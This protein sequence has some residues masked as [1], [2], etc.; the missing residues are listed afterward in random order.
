VNRPTFDD[1]AGA[2]PGGCELAELLSAYLDD[3]LRAPERE[4]VARHLLEHDACRRELDEIAQVRAAVRALPWIDGPAEF[5]SELAVE[6]VLASNSATGPVSA[7]TAVG[8]PPAPVRRIGRATS[9]TRWLWGSAAAGFLLIAAGIAGTQVDHTAATP[10]Q[11]SS[12]VSTV[13]VAAQTV[14]TS[15]STGPPVGQQLVV[16]NDGMDD[17]MDGVA[18]LLRMP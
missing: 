11:P 1:A 18:K 13:R 15:A 9:A 12:S 6:S 10:S 8:S 16:H 2:G 17:A 14:A 4:R 5:W 3:E 7:A